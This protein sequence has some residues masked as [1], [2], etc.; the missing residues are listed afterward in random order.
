MLEFRRVLFRSDALK[1]DR[2]FVGQMQ[3][4]HRNQKI[5]ETIIALSKQ[6]QLQVIAEGIETL[7]QWQTLKQLG[8]DRGQGFLFSPPL[9]AT[10]ATRFLQKHLGRHRG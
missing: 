6:L 4:N 9:E 7:Q 3:F 8:C 1:I 5:V 10:A 2:S